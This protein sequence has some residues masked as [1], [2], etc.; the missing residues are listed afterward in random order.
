MMNSNKLVLF[1]LC[2]V[3]LPAPAMKSNWFN[4][5]PAPLKKSGAWIMNHKLPILGAT[6]LAA[7]GLYYG[8]KFFTHANAN[9]KPV[10]SSFSFFPLPGIEPTVRAS[11]VLNEDG[12]LKSKETDQKKHSFFKDFNFDKW[13]TECKNVMMSQ[14]NSL[15]PLS[16]EDFIQALDAFCE[17]Q[18]ELYNGSVWVTQKNK[19]I[20]TWEKEDIKPPYAIQKLEVDPGTIIA[21]HGDFHG[22]VHSLNEFIAY[23]INKNYLNK[24]LKIIHPNFKII[25]L[26][27]YT[28]RGDYGAEVI[29]LITLLKRLN[30]ENVILVRGNHEDLV[31]NDDYGFTNELNRKFPF[32]VDTIKQKVDAMYSLLPVALYLVS[33]KAPAKDALLCCHGGL[34]FGFDQSALLL[35]APYS[36]CFIPFDELKR[37]TQKEKICTD[38]DL[39]KCFTHSYT[40]GETL[41]KEA[42]E[43]ALY[44]GPIQKFGHIGFCWS[45]F[46]FNQ[47]VTGFDPILHKLGRGFLYP[48][49][50]TRYLLKLHSTPTCNI[51]GVFRAHQHTAETI[52]RIFNGDGKNPGKAYGIAKLW[53]DNEHINIAPNRLWDGIVCT[54]C[55]SPNNEYGRL[56]VNEDTFGILTTANEFSQW[57]LDIVTQNTVLK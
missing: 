40:Y 44:D 11:D 33:S 22:D 36:K 26:G 35:D 54:F 50:L 49:N 4:Y 27:D 17:M 45:D 12:T 37:K 39:Q 51:R 31:I 38:H 56:G 13:R 21:F 2:I 57:N 28:D 15:S 46:D 10:S 52:N 19:N 41:E 32:C 24:Q 18:K 16:S 6:A 7:T 43:K 34:E 29:F 1:L 48:Q 8:Y 5:I 14:S 9:Q 55:V 47:D 42:L 3:S 20:H 25:F 53:P 30:P 23:L